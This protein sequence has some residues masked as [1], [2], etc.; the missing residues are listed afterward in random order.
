MS[1]VFVVNTPE[2]NHFSLMEVWVEYTTASLAEWSAYL[3][4]SHVSADLILGILLLE[5]SSRGI[6]SGTESTKPR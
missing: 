1:I 6:K 2:L 4:A 3:I 5:N